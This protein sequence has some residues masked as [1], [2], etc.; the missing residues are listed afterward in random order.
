MGFLVLVTSTI[1][2]LVLAEKPSVARGI[3]NVLKCHKKGNGYFRE[4]LKHT[5]IL[6]STSL[7]L[8][9]QKERSGMR[10]ENGV[11]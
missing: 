10:G 11:S 4:K 1:A 3:A 9:K 8:L 7:I 2:F 6:S 5:E